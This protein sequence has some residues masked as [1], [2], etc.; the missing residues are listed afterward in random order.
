M[1][2]LVRSNDSVGMETKHCK[3]MNFHILLCVHRY[4][5]IYSKLNAAEQALKDCSEAIKL[6]PSFT[7]AYL[8]RGTTY[9]KLSGFEAALADFDAALKLDKSIAE[10][11]IHRGTLL[12]SLG[13][14]DEAV[15]SLTTA[16][17]ISPKG[18]LYLYR[19][20]AYAKLGQTE[21]ELA[22]Y[23]KAVEVDSGNAVAYNNRAIF[24]LKSNNKDAALADFNKALEL[25]PKLVMVYRNRAYLYKLQG[26]TEKAKADEK[27]AET[28]EN[29]PAGND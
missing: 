29:P 1:G 25:N 6:D 2:A 5:L 26:E 18:T 19:A 24:Y 28:L 10:V 14:F 12:S 7:L 9:I 17:G 27:V 20:A 13:R 4:T 16:I 11:H 3:G 21:R 8:N 23:N 22:D 15:E